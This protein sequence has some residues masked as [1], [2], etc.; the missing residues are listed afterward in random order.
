[1]IVTDQVNQIVA[2]LA[3]GCTRT[4]ARTISRIERAEA[5]V[6]LLLKELYRL[7]GKSQ[8]IGVTGPPGAGKSS[9][10]N[11]LVNVIRKREKTVAVL[12]VDPSSPFTGGSVLGD[13][14]RMIEHG[15]DKGVFVRSM[16][17]R[18][19]LGGLARAAGDALT[20][21]DAM[22][23]DYVIVETV[24][25]GQNET[26]IMRYSDLVVL[27]QTPMGGDDVQ[28]TKAGINEIGDIFA[29]NKADHPDVNST[30]RQ[31]ET[32]INLN[33]KLNPDREWVPP[34]TKTQSI[35]GEGVDELLDQI[36]IRLQFLADRP[37]LGRERQRERIRHR[38]V[39]IIS[40]ELNRRMLGAGGELDEDLL[41][42]VVD[43]RSDPYELA[44][45][46]LGAG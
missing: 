2:R 8:V 38:T 34:V 28:A 3:D 35:S 41:A 15:L 19:H 39:E 12:A 14:F 23:W 31:L 42:P 17:S 45:T 21:L 16:A 32:M 27:V 10:V 40:G 36:D 33:Q 13:R 9:L 20:V 46:L 25:T 29:V 4:L 30:V 37:E 24:G 11:Q 7:G 18:G 26:E 5:E 6:T 22:P 1:M 43:R 44:D